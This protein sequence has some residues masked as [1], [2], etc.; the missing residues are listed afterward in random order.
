MKS[1][2]TIGRRFLVC[3]SL[4][5]ALMAILGAA[6]LV[7][8]DVLSKSVDAIVTDPL[9]G[10]YLASQLDS[11]VFQFRGDTWK[12]IAFADAAGKSAIERNQ[13]KIKEKVEDHLRSY[14]KTVTT[15]EDRALFG[16][17]QPLY[18]R[19]TQAIENA[20]LPLSRQGK[21]DEARAQYLQQ[22]DPVHAE[23]KEVL[24]AV[25]DLNRQ[26]GERD[27]AAAVKAATQG[28]TTTW[29]L[30]LVA[31][32]TGGAF[33]AI[34][35]RSVNRALGKTVTELSEGAAQ[36]AHAAAQVASAS[37]SLAQGSSEQAASLEE[38][39]AASEEISSMAR[40]NTDN[41]Q[42][43]AGVVAQSQQKF[44]ATNRLLDETVEAMGEIHAQS[45]KISKI[46]QTIDDIAFQTNI[47]ALNA[48][49]EAARAGE[50]GMGF[51]VVADEVRNLAQRCA[52]AAKDTAILI[53]ES[54]AKASD[55]KGKVDQVAVAIRAISEETVQA[56]T[57]VDEVSLGSQEQTHGIEQIS[58]AILQ[59]E[60]VTQTT[61][62]SAEEGAS[63]AEELTAQSESLKDIVRQLTEMVGSGH[64]HGSAEK[65]PVHSRGAGAERH[66]E[67]SSG[68]ASLG[69]AV[70]RNGARRSDT[71]LASS[72][73]IEKN[74]FP[75]EEEFKE[76]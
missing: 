1:R 47:L 23:L 43:A 57:L 67:M 69:N 6:S 71:R 7:C 39:S 46:I 32:V 34:S 49:V 8:I 64:S 63:A 54:V 73:K 52:Q 50:A 35:V 28:R 74:A 21:S 68:L 44:L 36:V 51:A 40:K 15:A 72:V 24:R 22:A 75:M 18:Q 31:F 25:V 30:L 45:G 26:T 59:M 20:V 61:A 10:V 41:S 70:S 66:G 38:T 12:H 55:G 56:K 16:R 48:A 19:Y 27:S 2:M 60:Q 53:E 58:K 17:V 3:S 76:F 62:A 37:Q 29:L 14:E 9:P 11:L 13:Q 4:P 5:L 33:V 42:A 65:A